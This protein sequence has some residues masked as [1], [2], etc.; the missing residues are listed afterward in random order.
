MSIEEYME[1]GEKFWKMNT[2]I[3]HFCGY[4]EVLDP[5]IKGV[6]FKGPCKGLWK[7]HESIRMDLQKKFSTDFPD[8][9]NPF[10]KDGWHIFQ[11]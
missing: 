3:S 4:P 10:T 5:P 6:F 2:A 9:D 11:K 1:I 8:K 7:Y